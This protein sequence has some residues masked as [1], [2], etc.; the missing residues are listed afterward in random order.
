MPG[1]RTV[2]EIPGARTVA[3]VPGARTVAE[4]PGARRRPGMLRTMALLFIMLSNQGKPA[5]ARSLE[6]QTNVMINPP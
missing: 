5:A 4:V 2:A 6:V 1:A 3:E